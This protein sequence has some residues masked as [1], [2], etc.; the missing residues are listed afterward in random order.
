MNL[1]TKATTTTMRINN[2]WAYVDKNLNW[3]NLDGPY[4]LDEDYIGITK[5]WNCMQEDLKSL[6][7]EMA[8]VWES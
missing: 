4:P 3:T 2:E 5:N 8:A 6:N 1:E 7:Q